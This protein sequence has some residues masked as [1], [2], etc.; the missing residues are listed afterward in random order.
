M[1]KI[2]FILLF[3]FLFIGCADVTLVE[4]CITTPPAGFW[5]GWWHG[6]VVP[7]SWIGSLIWDDV[8]VYAINNTGGWYDFGF[9]L[10]VGALSGFTVK[11][12]KR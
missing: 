9:A 6:I 7:I 10:G 2:L 11:S 4:E 1:K 8:A 3:I 12:S 5:A